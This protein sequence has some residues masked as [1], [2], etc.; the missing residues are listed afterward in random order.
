MHAGGPAIAHPS[1]PPVEQAL[2]HIAGVVV[3]CSNFNASDFRVHGATDMTIKV[4]PTAAA[5]PMENPSCSC[6]LTRPAWPPRG[7]S[8]PRSGSTSAPAWCVRGPH[9]HLHG[10]LFGCAPAAAVA[11]TKG[12]ALRSF[13]VFLSVKCDP[14]S[15]GVSGESPCRPRRTRRIK[16]AA[17][18]GS[19]GSRGSRGRRRAG[20]G[21]AAAAAAAVGG[22]VICCTPLTL[23]WPALQSDSV[24]IGLG[25]RIATKLTAPVSALAFSLKGG[26]GC[27][28]PAHDGSSAAG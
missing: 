18:A 19:R 22:H 14:C 11:E 27:V 15:H 28:A 2:S 16:V 4:W 20:A 26:E 24:S 1:R 3:F 13:R 21:A 12:S 23:I 8:R 25:E 17:A 10:R 7:P 6:K 9:I 5:I